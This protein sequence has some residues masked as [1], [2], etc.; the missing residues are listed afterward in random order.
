MAKKG[1]LIV[2]DGNDGS[3]KSTQVNLLLAR[4]RKEK[5]KF[6]FL[7]FPDYDNN[8]FG[9]FIGE[10][11]ANKEYKFLETHPKI[12][13]ALYA[14][15][16]W[17]SKKMLEA[18]LAKG[19]IVVLDRYVSANQIHQAGKI[20]DAK[21]RKEFLKWLDEMEFEVFKIPRPDIVFFLS[22]PARV[23]AKLRQARDKTDTRAYLK[24]KK[25]VHES[26]KRFMENSQKSALKL[27]KE[28]NN[29]VQVDCTA[30]GKML[31][32]E[33][34]H[35]KIYAKLKPLLKKS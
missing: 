10:C 5:R 1:K 12:I 2:I 30:K 28:L 33:N 31:S 3:G 34:I 7:H 21:E 32:R 26:N 14:A 17:E 23:S 29:F 24:N 19:N 16:R 35:E 4:L 15:D 20:P 8:F 11:L 9:A 6:K 27:V 18:W 13:S 22:V 25:D